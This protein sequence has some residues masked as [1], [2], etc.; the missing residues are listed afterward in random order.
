MP[1]CARRD[2]LDFVL[3]LAL[4]EFSE[5]I[6]RLREPVNPSTLFTERH[7]A[8]ELARLKADNAR[9]ALRLHRADHKC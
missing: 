8:V 1:Q 2:R 9:E 4:S 5:A 7:S 3:G 6:A